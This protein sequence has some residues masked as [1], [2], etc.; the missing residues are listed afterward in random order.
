MLVDTGAAGFGATTGKLNE[1]LAMADID[2]DRIDTVIL[3]HG[4]PDHLGEPECRRATSVSKRRGSDVPKRMG[5]L[6]V[7]SQSGRATRRDMAEG[8]YPD[9]D[10]PQPAAD[11]GAKTSIAGA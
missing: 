2:P 4:H 6:D 8:H 1:R 11:P 7:G 5:V 10:A 9:V 3:S